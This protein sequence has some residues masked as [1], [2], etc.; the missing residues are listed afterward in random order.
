M[1]EQTE[2]T[3]SPGE[4]REETIARVEHEQQRLYEAT[5]SSLNRDITSK[6]RL[7]S[8]GIL[9]G[10]VGAIV[11]AAIGMAVGLVVWNPVIPIALA[12]VGFVLAWLVTAERDDGAIAKR[13]EANLRSTDRPS[14]AD[15]S[16]R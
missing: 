10:L 12:V 16:H 1:D 7:G 4:S 2:G 13:A 5:G 14:G 3:P 15:R 11:F 9:R 6:R 8:R